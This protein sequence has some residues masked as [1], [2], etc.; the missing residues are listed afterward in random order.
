MKP[1]FE[2][3][4][5]GYYQLFMSCSVPRYRLKELDSLI[6]RILAHKASYEPASNYTGVPWFVVAIIH[7]MECELDFSKHLANG[8]DLGRRTI[9]DPVGIPTSHPG[10]FTFDEAAIA[11]LE[12]DRL[13]EVR[14]W[15]V[16]RICWE[17]EQYNGWGYRSHAIHSPYLWAGSQHYT[18]GKYIADGIWSA[19]AVSDQLGAAVI[20]NRMCALHHIALDA[21]PV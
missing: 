4:A 14:D 8:D 18:A 15:T 1:P 9:N 10:P 11:A 7:A 12:Y 13:D 3:A 5:P 21:Q 2:K 19:R 6:N 16:A 17:L 20:L